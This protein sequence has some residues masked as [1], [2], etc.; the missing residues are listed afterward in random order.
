[1]NLDR[2]IRT[3]LRDRADG[4]AA[5]P[6]IPQGT[7][8]RARV[9]KALMAGGMVVAVVTVAATGVV[10]RSAIWTDAAPVLPAEETGREILRTNGEVLSF[11]GAL[12]Q[13]RGDLVM[14]NPHTGEQRVL[15]EGLEAVYAATWSADGR[16]V[17]YDAAG[18]EGAGLWVVGASGE[19]RRVATGHSLFAWSSTGAELAVA[20]V[21]DPIDPD[22]AGSRLQTIDPVTG[23]TTDVGSIVDIGDSVTIP[24]AWSPDGTR[25]VYG[26][27]GAI[28]TADIESGEHSLLVRLPRGDSVDQIEWSPDGAHIA[29]Q[30]S[31]YLAYV[32]DAD[33]SNLR[34]LPDDPRHFAWSPD[35]ARLAHEGWSGIWV[36]SMDGSPPVE[37]ASFPDIC[38]PDVVGSEVQFCRHD[39]TWSPDGSRIGLWTLKQESVVVSAIDAGGSG[40]TEPIDELTHS[41]WDGGSYAPFSGFEL[42]GR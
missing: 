24:P 32:M 8:H 23:E 4:V 40:D 21:T 12:G 22:I 39:L 1:M 25:F 30:M 35:G 17:A 27:A 31:A 16:W 10:L 28:Y 18:L 15:V 5:A 26:A 14:V 33:G 29:V 37:V 6:V 7:V 19:P 2:D 42:V 13:S 41:S 3:M 9:R 20:R 34:V 11:T 38:D 36:S